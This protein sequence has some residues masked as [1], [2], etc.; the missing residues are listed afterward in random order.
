[1]AAIPPVPVPAATPPLPAKWRYVG[2]VIAIIVGILMFAGMFAF[3]FHIYA[4]CTFAL[5][6]PY[7]WGRVRAAGFL[8]AD[9]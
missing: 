2:P 6:C 4:C 1:M 3:L 7:E 5:G 9:S 8:P